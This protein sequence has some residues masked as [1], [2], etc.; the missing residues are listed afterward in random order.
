MSAT[1][2]STLRKIMWTG[3]YS[4]GSENPSDIELARIAAYVLLELAVVHHLDRWLVLTEYGADVVNEYAGSLPSD[5]SP[6]RSSTPKPIWC[7]RW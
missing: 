1:N 3:I 7:E 2:E 4:C 6:T 5:I